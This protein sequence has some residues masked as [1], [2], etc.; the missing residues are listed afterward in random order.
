[1]ADVV[2]LGILIADI[3]ARP[4]NEYPGRGHLNVCDEIRPSIGGC[5]ANTAIGLQKLGVPTG[6]IGKVG[7]DAFGDFVRATLQSH[8]LDA[9]GVVAAPE[10]ATS[11]T[12]VM[13]AGDG[14]RSFIH[15]VGANGAFTPD[16]VD[17]DLIREA[18]FLHVAGHFLMPGMDGEPVAQVLQKARELGVVTCLDTA[19]DQSQMS[20]EALRPSL[21]YLDYFVPSIEE[22]RSCARTL[23]GTNDESPA[24]IA[25]LFQDAG[26]GVVALKMGE[27]GSYIRAGEQEWEIPPFRVQAVD[28]TGAGDAYAAGFLAGIA[29]G[30]DLPTTGRLANAVG[31]LS[32]TAVGTVNG[33]R[34]LE[35]TLAF[36]EQG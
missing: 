31:A 29:K 5:A 10:G 27:A 19:G 18:K 14:E 16:D 12:M 1:M 6:V 34:S 7:C 22:A 15:Y 11:A 35:E 13:I 17:W 23:G 24:A 8:G 28:A 3:I 32:V 33:I 20:F 21:P 30:F 9:R 26:V 2:C 25:R 4:V 36:M